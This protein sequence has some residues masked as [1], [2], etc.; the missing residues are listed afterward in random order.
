MPLLIALPYIILEV[1]TFWGLATWLGVGWAL[2]VLLLCFFGGL[3]I[4]AFEMRRISQ[5]AAKQQIDPG[6]AAGDYGLLAA[7]AVLVALPGIASSLIGL[8]LIIPLTRAVVRKMLARKLR[9]SIEN[10]GVRSFEATNMYR[11]QASYGHFAD[12]NSAP[13]PSAATDS[14]H[15]VIDE[16]EIQQ[17]TSTLDP[18][19]FR[20][21]DDTNGSDKEQSDK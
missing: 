20:G 8:L 2:L 1:L 13:T 16:E 4:A 9:A 12:P 11:Q 3:W 19:D 17:W 18:D 7:G 15:P 14:A 10:M 6:R 5:A 21:G